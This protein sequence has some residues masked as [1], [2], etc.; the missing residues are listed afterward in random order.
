MLEGKRVEAVEKALAILDAFSEERTSMSLTEIA[1]E[2]GIS[3]SS[4]P[5]LL[6]SLALFGFVAR[7][8]AKQYKLGA[9]IWRL[10]ALYRRKFDLGEN[11]RP[12]LRALVD[13]TGETASYYVRDRDERIC[14]YR[15]NSPN[16]VRH[17]LDEGSRLSVYKGAAGHALSAEG[18]AW[19]QVFVSLG[20]RNRDVAAI[21]IRVYSSTGEVRGALCVSGIISRF[22]ETARSIAAKRLEIS[23]RVLLEP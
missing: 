14:L 23:Q 8:S 22:D 18:G 13:A 19:D 11:I 1:Q 15:L 2:T 21:A 17:H 10:G 3:K 4:L 12:E 6:T 20:E 9:N 7:D 16:S 5:R